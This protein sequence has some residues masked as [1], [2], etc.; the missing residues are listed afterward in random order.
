MKDF[1]DQMGRKISLPN[2]PKRIVSLV[3]SQTE[4][5][6][7]LGLEERVVGITWFCVHPKG[8]VDHKAKIGGTKNV[9]MEQVKALKPDLIIANKEENVKSQVEALAEDCPVWVSDV[10]DLDSALD[11]IEELGKVTETQVTAALYHKRI[12]EKWAKLPLYPPL[13]TLYFIWRK[14]YMS[15]GNDTFIHF[16]LNRLGLKNACGDQSRYPELS[17]A[18]LKALK[19]ELILLSS[20]PYPFKEK[21]LA[22]FREICPDARIMMVDGE[23]F[24]WYGSRLLKAGTYFEELAEELT[25]ANTT[26]PK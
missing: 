16:I 22:E 26:L 2:S 20:E 1:V 17:K 25:E 24:S 11:M 13:K 10:Y 21:H 18:D 4:L 19:P 15:V 5:L 3:P 8:K 12:K 7:D 6:F 9:K 23:F 14:P